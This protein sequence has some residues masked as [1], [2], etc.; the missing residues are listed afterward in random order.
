MAP[1]AALLRN[2]AALV[3]IAMPINSLADSCGF[4]PVFKQPDEEGEKLV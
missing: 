4:R 2:V 1:S 3:V